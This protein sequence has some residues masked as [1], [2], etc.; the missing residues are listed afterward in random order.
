MHWYKTVFSCVIMYLCFVAMSS[1]AL[2]TDA[3]KRILNAL[4]S[5]AGGAA[6]YASERRLYD[7]AKRRISLSKI[8]RFLASK[9]AYSLLTER[10]RTKKR[11]RG[12]IFHPIAESC[13]QF[14]MD[15]WFLPKLTPTSPRY[16]ILAIC[17]FSR[18]T[19][20]YVTRKLNSQATTEALRRIIAACGRKPTSVFIDR[21]TCALVEASA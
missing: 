18:F 5:D 8:R 11:N 7:A 3:D 15:T 14:A 1:S 12:R 4:W 13:A 21:G 10:R 9:K 16:C 19:F 17:C 20:A 6:G 2:L